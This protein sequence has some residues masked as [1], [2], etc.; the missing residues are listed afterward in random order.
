MV[1]NHE[2]SHMANPMTN[3][4]P[5]LTNRKHPLAE[6]LEIANAHVLA[7]FPRL[8]CIRSP[9]VYGFKAGILALRIEFPWDMNQEKVKVAAMT[10]ARGALRRHGCDSAVLVCEAFASRSEVENLAPKDDPAHLDLLLLVAQTQN[11]TPLKIAYQVANA[12]KPD[13]V[14]LENSKDLGEGPDGLMS[15]LFKIP[16]EPS[17]N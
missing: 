12:G 9:Y 1:P 11:E 16:F 4:L 3:F 10:A 2:Q 5:I 7:E 13:A 15:S 14:I 8:R 6:I 17:N